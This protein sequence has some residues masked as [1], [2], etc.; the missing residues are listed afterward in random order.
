[1]NRVAPAVQSVCRPENKVICYPP[2][3]CRGASSALFLLT[4]CV[5]ER[6]TVFVISVVMYCV[7]VPLH[8]LNWPGLTLCSSVKLKAKLKPI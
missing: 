2:S 4:V 8:Y 7:Y 1:M 5:R 3:L 6:E